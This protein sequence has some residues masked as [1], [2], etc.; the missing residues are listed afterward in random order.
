METGFGE[1]DLNF[2]YVRCCEDWCLEATSQAMRASGV[3]WLF[4]KGQL[5][6]LDWDA[7]TYQALTTILTTK[8]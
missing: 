5:C 7:I 3:C 4:T 8:S 6:N 2:I 1:K